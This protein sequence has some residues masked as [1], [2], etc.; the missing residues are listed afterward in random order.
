MLRKF[1]GDA[2]SIVLSEEV[3]TERNSICDMVPVEILDRKLKRLRNKKVAFVN[4]FWRNQKVKGATWEAEVDM[5]KCYPYLFHS[6]Q[7]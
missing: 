3:N 6:T 4:L 7:G 1:I 5:M 2:N